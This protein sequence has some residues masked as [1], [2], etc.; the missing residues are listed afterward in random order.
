MITDRNVTDSGLGERV[1][2]LSYW[3]ADSDDVDVFNFDESRT[4]E[5]MRGILREVDRELLAAQFRLGQ[6][7]L[8]APK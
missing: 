3:T 8:V 7:E 4:I 5:L 1:A 6:G 2:G